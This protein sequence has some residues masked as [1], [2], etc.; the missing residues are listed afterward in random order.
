MSPTNGLFY[1]IDHYPG[2]LVQ[3]LDSLIK[4][5]ALV[6]RT[7]SDLAQN[8]GAHGVLRDQRANK[9]L[10]VRTQ[11]RD[12][13]FVSISRM[14]ISGDIL[15]ITPI[16]ICLNLGAVRPPTP[17]IN[18]SAVPCRSKFLAARSSKRACRSLRSLR[19]NEWPQ[20]SS[21]GISVPVDETAIV[22][23]RIQVSDGYIQVKLIIGYH[24]QRDHKKCCSNILLAL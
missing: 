8:H 6:C 16:S 1:G 15:V 5:R 13:S 17:C 23:Y 24:Y 7:W 14:T 19:T 20:I 22:S 18:I 3:K 12:K 9:F 10:D 21:L 2:I 4:I 11:A